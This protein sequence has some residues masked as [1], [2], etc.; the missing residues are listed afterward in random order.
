MMFATAFSVIAESSSKISYSKICL[1]LCG[2]NVCVCRQ[3]GVR[4]LPQAMQRT[5]HQTAGRSFFSPEVLHMQRYSMSASPSHIVYSF[6]TGVN[7]T[8][9]RLE[10]NAY[11]RV[12]SAVCTMA[13]CLSVCLSQVGLLSRRIV[14]DSR[15]FWHRHRGYTTGVLRCKEVRVSP[16][17]RVVSP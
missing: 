8:A 7:F 4:E 3:S 12:H 2:G 10:R 5:G 1:M 15:C 13:S 9:W 11:R 16:E 6:C 17:M 14:N